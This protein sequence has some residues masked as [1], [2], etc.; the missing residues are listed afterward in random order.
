MRKRKNEKRN[1][2]ILLIILAVITIISIVRNK[3]IQ[4]LPKRYVIGEVIRTRKPPT[5][6]FVADFSFEIDG[7]EYECD[8]SLYGYHGKVKR[9]QRYLV[10]V[11][12]D[13]PNYSRMLF[14]YPIPKGMES[15]RH[16]WSEFP[17]EITSP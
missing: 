17:Q 6:D 8:E 9:Y 7:I 1:V 3:H 14:K 13:Y 10:A 11:P 4:S 15:P 12:E 16:G 2:I 5:G